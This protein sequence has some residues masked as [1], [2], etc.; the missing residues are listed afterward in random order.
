MTLT[1]DFRVTNGATGITFLFHAQPVGKT[2]GEGY[3][4]QLR[5]VDARRRRCSRRPRRA[6]RTSRSSSVTDF[7]VGDTLTVDGEQRTIT[8]VGHAGPR[9]HALGA[10]AA[11]ATNVKVASVTGLV[12]G[13][14]IIIDGE[15]RTIQTVGT[16][17]AAGT[18]VTLTQ[19][20]TC[21][22]RQRR[23]GALQRHRASASRPR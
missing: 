5:S 3:Q 10:A 2:W 19:A 7:T 23:G 11:G 18:G 12:A 17:G 20:L 15:T 22:A 9:D 21:G 16:Q 6:T 14:P 1:S 13:E 8:A 4:W